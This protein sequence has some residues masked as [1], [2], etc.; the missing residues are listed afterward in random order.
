MVFTNLKKYLTLRLDDDDVDF[1]YNYR[2]TMTAQFKQ[3]LYNKSF[4]HQD[5]DKC[6]EGLQKRIEHW[7]NYDNKNY[8]KSFFFR[9]SKYDPELREI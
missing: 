9:R 4:S 2:D 3:D 1:R 8:G 6:E 5:Q 7:F